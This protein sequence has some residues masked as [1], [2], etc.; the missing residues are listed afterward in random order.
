MKYNISSERYKFICYRNRISV[1][2][3]SVEIMA[4][5]KCDNNRYHSFI[6]TFIKEGKIE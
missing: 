6:N 5:Y 4:I 3:P 1:A 2:T